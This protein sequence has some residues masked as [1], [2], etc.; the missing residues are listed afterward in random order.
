MEGFSWKPI[1]RLGAYTMA[2]VTR[3]ISREREALQCAMNTVPELAWKNK[4]LE[5]CWEH[6]FLQATKA[7]N[8]KRWLGRVRLEG[9]RAEIELV[10]TFGEYQKLIAQAGA[11]ALDYLARHWSRSGEEA[12]D[13]P[14]VRACE[15]FVCLI[16]VACVL[17]LLARIRTLIVAIG[18][19]YVLILLGIAQYPF[20]PRA[21]IQL[22]L[23]VL[24][25]FIVYV[26]GGVF[27]QM[28]RDS[29]LSQITGTKAGELGGDFWVRMAS[30]A[31]LPLFTLLSSQFPSLNRALYTW[32]RPAIEAL[33]R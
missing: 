24:L 4:D 16:Y 14:G 28:H 31:A 7:R 30:F 32:I 25:A 17:G 1:W 21:A 12:E 20:E 13:T 5:T 11:M 26:V 27:A 22:S 2:E 6:V 3:I 9:R 33:N 18:G 10:R 29:T 8:C 23:I 19:M 15:R